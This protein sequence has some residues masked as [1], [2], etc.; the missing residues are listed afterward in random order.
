MYIGGN[1]LT[2]G[3]SIGVGTR[4]WPNG[5]QRGCSRRR[6]G[7][8]SGRIDGIVVVFVVFMVAVLM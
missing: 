7:D 4:D 8:D 3:D 5:R 2:I 6:A 1:R